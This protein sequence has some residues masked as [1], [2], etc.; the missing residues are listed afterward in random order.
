MS[1]FRQHFKKWDMLGAETACHL[2]FK[3][4]I[5]KY[6]ITTG[7][8]FSRDNSIFLWSPYPSHSSRQD[9]HLLPEKKTHS[10]Y[11]G[12]V[13]VQDIPWAFLIRNFRERNKRHLIVWNHKAS[14]KS[15]FH[16]ASYSKTFHLKKETRIRMNIFQ[17]HFLGLQRM[18]YKIKNYDLKSNLAVDYKC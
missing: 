11:Q 1:F 7:F 14:N 8:F 15:M 12:Q 16:T 4:Y 9:P 17:V 2:T 3:L 10:C 18:K 6:G 13:I 5:F